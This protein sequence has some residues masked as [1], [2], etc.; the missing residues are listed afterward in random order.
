L[1]FCGWDFHE[2]LMILGEDMM[3]FG[4]LGGAGVLGWIGIHT[5]SLLLK[6]TSAK[7]MP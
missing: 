2:D 4:K 1:A 7:I 5:V 3:A 6:R